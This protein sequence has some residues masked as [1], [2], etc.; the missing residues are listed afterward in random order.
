M[1]HD[2]G[3]AGELWD[4]MAWSNWLPSGCAMEVYARANDNRQALVNGVFVPVTNN[5]P[6]SGVQGR[7]IEVRV[8]LTRD[9][10]SQ[11]PVLYDLTLFGTSWA[12]G[13]NPFLA[14]VSTN[15]ATDAVFQ[16]NVAGPEPLV[17]HWFAQ[18]PWTNAAVWLEEAT[19]ATLVLSNVDSWV[20]GT[21]A[22]VSVSNAA[23]QTL[24]L[25]PATLSVIPVPIAIPGTNAPGLASRYPAEIRVFGQ[26]TNL[27][28]VTVTL[29]DLSH[30]IPDDLDIVLESPLGP[31]AMLMSDAGGTNYA[32]T[33]VTLVFRGW[34]GIYEPP[35]DDGPIY[36][37]WTYDFT[38]Y[39]YGEQ[40]TLP[41]PAPGGTY[42]TDLNDL[43]GTN[44]NGVWKLYLYDD[45]TGGVGTL[46]G[47][48]RLD[49]TFD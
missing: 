23:G 36:P 18:Y 25:G 22:S 17:Y 10:V 5:A 38:T 21:L 7:F 15:E 33:N 8:S 6:L 20:T 48:W 19:N 26:P 45:T 46:Q 1:I 13:G 14:N 9:D 34:E 2:C 41:T 16:V 27:A 44:P 37:N 35:P 39:N 40:E 3:Y 43:I 29:F 47:S 42:S 31:H 32:L 28:S 30:D 12:F 4:R 11:L 49:F 24:W